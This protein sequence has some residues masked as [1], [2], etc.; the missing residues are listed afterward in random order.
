MTKRCFVGVDL[1]TADGAAP[2]DAKRLVVRTCAVAIL[3]LLAGLVTRPLA[4]ALP[5]VYAGHA[6]LAA[7]LYAAVWAACVRRTEHVACCA[8]GTGAVALLLGSMRAVMGWG[9]AV[10]L[11]CAVVAY[12]VLRKRSFEARSL[13]SGMAFG[14]C[15]YPATLAV[16]VASGSYAIAADAIVEPMLLIALGCASSLLGALLGGRSSAEGACP[17]F[18]TRS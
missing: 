18:R 2:I 4:L 15:S 14:A 13:L 17:R 10:P 7:P 8:V 16:S 1:E 11:A 3:I 6:V 9:L 5:S 12:A